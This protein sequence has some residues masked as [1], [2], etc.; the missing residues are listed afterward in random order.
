MCPCA[1]AGRRLS[2]GGGS[3]AA[4]LHIDRFCV[5]VPDQ[6][7]HRVLLLAD[8][9]ALRVVDRDEPRRSPLAVE[10][11][12][13]GGRSQFG[14]GCGTGGVDAEDDVGSRYAPRVEPQIL[15]PGDF[16]RQLGV[17]TGR[18]PDENAGVIGQGDSLMCA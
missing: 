10:R 12:Q 4:G 6:A 18:P 13:L 16:E 9:L 15:G 8:V 1:E 7:G 3:T 5:R 2:F 14:A 11:C 17:V